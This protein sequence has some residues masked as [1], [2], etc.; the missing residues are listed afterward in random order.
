MGGN[1]GKVG[2]SCSFLGVVNAV[3]KIIDSK[4]VPV[5]IC[6]DFNWC[7]WRLVE[8]E[9]SSAN[10]LFLTSAVAAPLLPAQPE[11]RLLR[12]QPFGASLLQTTP[13][14]SWAALPP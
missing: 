14:V 9:S 7:L 11:E 12:D 2:W 6:E 1:I 3:L 4:Q 10:C 5:L 13:Q 8:E